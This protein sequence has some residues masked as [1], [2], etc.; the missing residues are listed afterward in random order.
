[1]NNVIRDSKTKIVITKDKM[2][3][4][5]VSVMFCHYTLF[6]YFSVIIRKLPVISVA[7]VFFF[8]ILYSLLIILSYRESRLRYVRGSDLVIIL[9]FTVSI[10]STY[11]FYPDNALYI[12]ASL[13]S[14][15]LP[16][17]PFF[18]LGLCL[19]L[20]K[21]TLSIVSGFSCTAILVSAVYVL[22]YMG[23]G[24]I[25][26]GDVGSGYSM[27][28]SYLLLPNT[29]IA[30][31]YAFEKKKIFAI[32]CS[33]IGVIYALAMGTRGAIVVLFVFLIVRIW[34]HLNIN[35][36]KKVGI[37]IV[38]SIIVFLFIMSPA[39]LQM[40]SDIKRLLMRYGLSTRVVD[41]L[42]SGEL[43]SYT[44]GRTDIYQDLFSRFMERPILGYGIYG[45]WTLG[46]YSAHNM[47]MEILFHYGFPIGLTLMISFVALYFKALK[48]TKGTLV[49]NWII[50]FGCL[51]FV[52]GIFGGRY[53]DYSLF[54]LLGLCLKEIRCAK[55][56]ITKTRKVML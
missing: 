4:L 54:F 16:C 14:N 44:S 50:M 30:I 12:S 27:Y 31:E 49:R 34:T 1:M 15:I 21:E 48:A 22:Y 36:N 11:I 51:V 32:I 41:Y 53:L 39:Y 3:A 42:I 43:V 33:I 17:I 25:L 10:L 7:E 45:E 18:L 23:T 5:L 26:G 20:D 19:S 52:K 6:N 40:L 47:Y 35:I 13:T 9:F 55:E 24:R 28:W 8:P 29:I 46:Y 2:F 38:L 56:K 37:A